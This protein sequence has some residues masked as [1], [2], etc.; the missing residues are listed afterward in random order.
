MKKLTLALISLLALTACSSN[1]IKP[2]SNE[3][4]FSVN[5]K[6]I[7]EKDIFNAMKLSSGSVGIIYQQAQELLFNSLVEEDDAFEQKVQEL[8]EEAK[9]Y[10][11]DN[12]ELTI[13][14]NGFENEQAYVDGVLKPLA[15]VEIALTKVMSDDYENLKS[16]RP[17]QVRI[18]EVEIEDG[19]K[20]LELLKANQSFEDLY[21]EYGKKTSYFSGSKILVSEIS[22][23]DTTVLNAI[24]N[25]EN[26]GILSDVITTENSAFVVEILSNDADELKDQAIKTFILNNQL[27]KQ[28]LGQLFR[29][30]KFTLYD[31]DLYDSFYVTYPDFKK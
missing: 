10:M 3:L 24:L 11:G 1:T 21:E 9:G 12:F 27:M 4:L 18:L 19:K 31:Q 2:I 13:Q 20:V 17:R 7:H 14:Q 16:K 23:M 28:Y 29:D 30:Y 25:E 15:R 5:G 6:E 22:D 8:L 26:I